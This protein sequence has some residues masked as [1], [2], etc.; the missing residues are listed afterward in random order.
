[1]TPPRRA[2]LEPCDVPR[3]SPDYPGYCRCG[4]PMAEHRERFAPGRI[5][6]ELPGAPL[7]LT[8]D[9]GG[10][11]W[12]LDGRPLHGGDRVEVLAEV[13]RQPCADCDG[14]GRAGEG[15]GRHRCPACI[16]RGYTFEAL[17][18]PV[19]FEYV[20]A[21]DGSGVAYLYPPIFGA[22]PEERNAIH[23]RRG[24]A[25]RCRWPAPSRPPL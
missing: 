12:T 16:G 22:L 1:M 13:D 6:A 24:D 2:S 3:E 14:E 25:V 23:I 7:V 18:L 5:G 10:E 8:V 19:L 11:R 9:T 4:H 15:D 21:G 20:N 17:W